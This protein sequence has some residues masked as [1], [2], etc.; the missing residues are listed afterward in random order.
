MTTEYPLTL[1]LSDARPPAGKDTALSLNA[2]LCSSRTHLGSSSSETP[3]SF[4]SPLSAVMRTSLYS[5]VAPYASNS[6]TTSLACCFHLLHC[7]ALFLVSLLPSFR[8][9]FWAPRYWLARPLPPMSATVGM[10]P[11]SVPS[12]QRV[13]CPHPIRQWGSCLSALPF[14][15]VSAQPLCWGIA[16]CPLSPCTSRSVLQ[17]HTA[18]QD[19]RAVPRV[20][21]HL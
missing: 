2:S 19:L 6:R 8:S 9:L 1:S 3:L 11:H 17:D 5:P 12:L 4:S 16:P 7:S 21:R 20:D 14:L 15:L 13:P 10:M 18:R